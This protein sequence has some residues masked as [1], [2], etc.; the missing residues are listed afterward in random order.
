MI[1]VLV[2]V[3]VKKGSEDVF[4]QASIENAKSS[5]TEPGFLRFDVIQQADDPSRF[6]L[7][8]AYQN[9][10]VP[11]KHKETA[12]YLKWRGIVD[13][14]MEDTRY[15]VKYNGCFFDGKESA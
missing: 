14:L 2:H 9:A 8:E 12:H 13:P 5:L 4:R 6:I 1:A 15:G 7:Y 11:V 3:H 10:E